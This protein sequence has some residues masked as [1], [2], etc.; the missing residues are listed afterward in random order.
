MEQ[1]N[2]ICFIGAGAITNALLQGFLK[3]GVILPTDVRI[4]NRSNKEKLQRL[5]QAHQIEE[6][7]EQAE[8]VQSAD[9]LILAVKPAD[10]SDAIKTWK[11]YLQEHQRI[12]SVA[13]GV[14]TSVIEK[15]LPYRLPVIRVMPNTSSSIGLSATAI[16]K[17]SWSSARDLQ[18]TEAL[19]TSIGSVIQIEEE[20]M[21]AVTALSG[22]GPAYIYYVAEA[23]TEAG[24][25]VG[26]DPDVARTLT[27]QTLLGAAHMLEQADESPETLRKQVTSPGGTTEAG[28][29]TLEEKQWKEV[30]QEAVLRAKQRAQ[31]LGHSLETKASQ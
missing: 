13:A 11:P 16:C 28:I 30:L 6:T 15:A 14:H 8:A 21:D 1:N 25:Q 29:A 18:Y 7:W 22:S 20:Q 9:T 31:E 19:L 23:L 17:G 10:I 24:T 2:I 3:K 27:I 4:I 12:I 5:C 26:L